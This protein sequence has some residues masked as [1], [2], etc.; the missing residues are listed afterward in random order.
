MLD[1]KSFDKY[2]NIN[3]LIKWKGYDDKDNTWEPIENIYCEDLIKEFEKTYDDEEYYDCDKCLLSI[4]K[5][6]MYMLVSTTLLL[7]SK[8]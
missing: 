5:M 3:Y 1:D 7:A 2:G 8:F 4:I 6:D